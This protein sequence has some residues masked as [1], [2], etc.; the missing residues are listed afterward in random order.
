[1]KLVS[2]KILNCIN[3][4]DMK[5]MK[6]MFR[7]CTSILLLMS[8]SITF[9]DN[10][11][12]KQYTNLPTVYININSGSAIT[13]KK[14]WKISQITYI[15]GDSTVVYCNVK[16][17]GRG[18]STWSSMSKKA[19]RIQFPKQVRLLGKCSSEAKDWT[20][21]ANAADKTLLRNALTTDVM[22]HAFSMGFCPGARFVDLVLNG[23][24]VGNYQI[25]DH[26]EVNNLRVNISQQADSVYTGNDMQDGYFL[27]TD[28][29]KDGNYFET[30]IQSVPVRVHYPKKN[31]ITSTQQTKIK[32]LVNK[33]EEA[34]FSVDFKDP[35]KGYRPLVDSVSLVNLY[36]ATELCANID[37]FHSMYF[38]KKDGEDR[39]Y[40]GPMW[41]YD[42]AYAN[43]TRKGDTSHTIMADDNGAF[44]AARVWFKQMWNDPWFR[45][46]VNRRWTEMRHAGIEKILIAAVDS[47]SNMINAS[48]KLNYEVWGINTKV[49]H[50]RTIHSSYEPYVDDLKNFIV[51]RC[52][53]LDSCFLARLR[54][55]DNARDTSFTLLPDYFYKIINTGNS[56]TMDVENNGTTVGSCICLWSNMKDRETEQWI[57]EKAGDSYYRI[58]N[59]VS[60]LFL[61]DPTE[62]SCTA[63]T[64]T[65]TQLNLVESDDSSA[66]LWQLLPQNN[67]QFNLINKFTGHTANVKGGGSADG[68][69]IISYNTDTKNSTSNNRKWYIVPDEENPNYSTSIRDVVSVSESLRF[70]EIY[71]ICGR[72]IGILRGQQ[73][74][75]DY[76]SGK[77]LHGI[78]IIKEG[79][80]INK[81]YIK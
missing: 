35:V 11:G 22:S 55:H 36:I 57:I 8:V 13:S 77:E 69:K 56:K 32:N 15:D 74:I 64:N 51:E 27:E 42:I 72:L 25:S 40:F 4:I 37:G 1:M 29:W 43:D 38:Y 49:Y 17:R 39:F 53:F 44:G 46:V 7:L 80:K 79:S 59:R 23:K 9:G 18:N 65:G 47:M 73:N 20:L 45:T 61:N 52:T 76:L 10:N 33:F 71:D 16:I 26:P 12:L 67:K 34:L 6:V 70:I 41:D 66:Q 21:M 50:E 3:N 24:Y 68:T 5:K 48:Q 81:V 58:K 54:A 14:E 60:G 78:Y 2:V 75:E 30:G 63:T 19:Y 62:G 28:G 31:D